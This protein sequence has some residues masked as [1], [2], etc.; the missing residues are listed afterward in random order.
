MSFQRT[1]QDTDHFSVRHTCMKGFD[2]IFVHNFKHALP[3][4]FADCVSRQLRSGSG[5]DV[6]L[7]K[8]HT[9]H[10]LRSHRGRDR[11]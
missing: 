8:P 7:L 6:A 3:E 11:E 5:H 4:D 9:N 1:L 2:G 10:T